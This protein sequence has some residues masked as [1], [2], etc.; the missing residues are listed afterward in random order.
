MA[1]SSLVLASAL[2][3]QMMIALPALGRR[4]LS[5]KQQ[6]SST[7]GRP[8]HRMGS[9]PLLIDDVIVDLPSC[10]KFNKR[11]PAVMLPADDSK[12]LYGA[13]RYSDFVTRTGTKIPFN[14]SNV[15]PQSILDDN[16]LNEMVMR[17]TI[18]ANGNITVVQPEL[19]IDQ[20]AMMQIFRGMKFVG[21]VISG[22]DGVPAGVPLAQWYRLDIDSAFSEVQLFGAEGLNGSLVNMFSP[23][24][25]D[26]S[27]SCKPAFVTNST[28]AEWYEGNLGKGSAIQFFW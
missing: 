14:L 9:V 16:R 19:L 12:F 5:S 3:V 21:H 10:L 22:Y 26:D 23:V 2:M 27:G 1:R 28:T 8:C 17:A 13:V 25:D 4:I 20:K 7:A 6:A 11:G 24:S 18:D 15:I